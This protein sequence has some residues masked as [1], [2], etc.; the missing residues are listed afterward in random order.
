MDTLQ[1]AKYKIFST[2]AYIVICIEILEW[3]KYIYTVLQPLQC[4][5][6]IS[7][8]KFKLVQTLD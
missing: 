6:Q 3:Q 4:T 5:L 1:L 8:L 7:S 2:L